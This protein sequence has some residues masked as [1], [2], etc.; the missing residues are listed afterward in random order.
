MTNEDK[1]FNKLVDWY[2]KVDTLEFIAIKKSISDLYVAKDMIFNDFDSLCK[3]IEYNATSFETRLKKTNYR[4]LSTRKIEKEVKK[5][6]K[7]VET[8][9]PVCKL[10][11]DDLK[12][13][14]ATLGLDNI[15]NNR[16]GIF[17]EDKLYTEPHYTGEK[18]SHISVY[19]TKDK[20]DER[21]VAFDVSIMHKLVHQCTYQGNDDKYI[22]KINQSTEMINS[23]FSGEKVV[24]CV[25]QEDKSIELLNHIMG[26]TPI[27]SLDPISEKTKR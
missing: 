1:L 26:T 7:L 24:L 2:N 15:V 4:N 10:T 20:D 25:S 14:K 3:F 12:Y 18:L 11:I 9:F 19:N 22:E 27:K 21:Y 13:G 17:F 5:Y 8:L 23:L 16:T 6:S